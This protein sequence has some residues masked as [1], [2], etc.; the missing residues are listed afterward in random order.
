MPLFPS[1]ARFGRV[2]D[3]ATAAPSLS[4]AVLV[5]VHFLNTAKVVAEDWKPRALPKPVQILATTCS[6]AFRP[7]G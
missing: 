3:S 1:A 4:A 2:E 6:V 7:S 5:S